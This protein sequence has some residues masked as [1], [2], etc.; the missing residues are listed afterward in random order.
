[1]GARRRLGRAGGGA[2]S[3]GR[4]VR[5]ALVALLALLTPAALL[6]ESPRADALRPDV[7]TPE[8][9]LGFRPGEDRHLADWDQ[10]LAYLARLDAASDRVRVEELGKTTQGRPFV[11]ATVTSEANQARLEEIREVNLRLADPRGLGE[12]EAE[13]L[14]HEG[15]AIVA[16]AF[17]I[18]S[19]EVG[20]TL[21]A[22]RL[23]YQLA[24]SASPDVE[25]ILDEVVLLVLPSHNPDG[26]QLVAEWYRNELGT[27][28]EGTAPPV[29]Y[30][31]YVGH[32]D[33]RDWYMFTQVET[34]LTVER[35]HRR[36]HPQIMH[37]VHQ[38]GPNGARLFVPPYTDPWEPNVDPALVAA[39]NDLGTYVASVLTTEGGRASSPTPSSTPGRRPAPTRTPTAGC[40]CCRRRPRP[41]SRRP[42]RCARRSSS[43][44]RATTRDGRPG[45]SP[46]PGPGA[47]G[48]S[49]TSSTSSLRSRSPSSITPRGTGSTGCGRS[50]ASAV[51][52]APAASRGP[53][54][55]PPGSAT[56]SP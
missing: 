13:R 21:A 10:V 24:A 19:T 51:G 17:S 29:L 9:V 25:R 2:G 7:P 23:L 31:P 43:P 56:P 48:G 37:D 22:L 3:G 6:S 14:V 54:S 55:S 34:R 30:H 38:M 36:W 16:M 18:H 47:S 46:P 44:A 4:A 1:M 5:F 45:T 8:S 32:D 12:E 49:P 35:L 11:M 26:T 52:P 42:S 15:R 39:V 53:S 27:P 20:G 28:F 33:N 40:G 41:G 50:S